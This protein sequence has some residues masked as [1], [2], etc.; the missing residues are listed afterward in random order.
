[1][2]PSELALEMKALI[3]LRETSAAQVAGLVVFLMSK[4]GTSS[5]L[6]ERAIA[7]ILR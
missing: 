2:G 6:A 5:L 3:A 1:M 4:Y 7:G